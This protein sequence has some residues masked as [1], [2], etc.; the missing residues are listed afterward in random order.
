[1]NISDNPE[2]NARYI[3]I[4]RE[5]HINIS[6]VTH[7]IIFWNRII[8]GRRYDWTF[9]LKLIWRDTALS[10]DVHI[11]IDGRIVFEKDL[12]FDSELE[13]IVTQHIH[14]RLLDRTDRIDHQMNKD[15]MKELDNLDIFMNDIIAY[16]DKYDKSILCS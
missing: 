14:R 9:Y 11:K 10:L 1:M 2:L 5:Q 7:N 8:N 12:I 4:I 3:N 6:A 16:M 13:P 15:Q